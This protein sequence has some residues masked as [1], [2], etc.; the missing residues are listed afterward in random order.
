MYKLSF[1]IGLLSIGALT[2]F[3]GT[4]NTPTVGYD[5]TTGGGTA[6]VG[7]ANGLLAQFDPSLGTLTGITV[8]IDGDFT[9]NLHADIVAQGPTSIFADFS[10]GA[11]LSNLP[12]VS[13]FD[14]SM[15][16]EE[17]QFG[18][19]GVGTEVVSCNIDQPFTSGLVFGEPAPLAPTPDL[20]A[21]IGLG[22]VPFTVGNF[23][24][25]TNVNMGPSTGSDVSF[26]STE[27]AGDIYLQYTYDPAG[28]STPEPGSF[29]LLAGGLMLVAFAR[30]RKAFQ[31]RTVAPARNPRSA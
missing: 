25:I 15:E 29:A 5:L 2:V 14:T 7:T 27:I 18:C 21:Y 17:L 3:A 28:V 6:P 13:L 8:F 31:T 30:Y 19:T 4:I 12:G 9:L 1:L 10:E 16:F 26:N 22:T 20:S 24:S 11:T 23:T